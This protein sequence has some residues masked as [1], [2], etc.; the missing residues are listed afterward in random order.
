[1]NSTMADLMWKDLAKNYDLKSRL[2]NYKGQ[3]TI[4]K[5]RQDVIP[6]E[7]SFLIKE[8]IPQTK[9]ISI[10]RCGHMP[11]LE[12]PEAFYPALKKAFSDNF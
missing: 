12:K 4:I 3:C 11:H 9:K 8:L 5:P 7:A 10:E 2:I 1:M 6:E